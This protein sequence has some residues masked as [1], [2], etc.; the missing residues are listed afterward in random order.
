MIVGL[1]LQDCLLSRKRTGLRGG[2]WGLMCGQ[3]FTAHY[4]L[5]FTVSRS[6]L[7]EEASAMGEL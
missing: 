1:A 5:L 3:G 7:K 2:V 6:E 4:S